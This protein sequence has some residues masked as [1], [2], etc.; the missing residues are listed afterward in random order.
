MKILKKS[1]LIIIS[2]MLL[3]C[4]P[5]YAAV[6]AEEQTVVENEQLTADNMNFDVVFAIDGSGSMKTSDAL[7]LRLTA[8]RL[9]TELAASDTSRA[10]YVQFTNV[11]MESA[12]LTEL[13]SAE[14]KEMFRNSLAGLKDSVRGTWD[15]DISLGLTEAL[16]ILKEGE[17]FGNDRNPVIILLSD[18][19]TDLPSGPRTV[20]ESN[21][22]LTATLA[23]AAQLGVPIYS[24]GLNWDGKLDTDYMQNIANQTG[25]E[26]YNITTASEFNQYIT[27]IFGNVA[28]GESTDLK[29]EYVNGRYETNFV[30]DNSSVLTANIVILTDK[31]VSDPQLTNPAGTTVPLDEEHGVIVSRDVSDA[32]RISTYTILKIMYP[33]QGVWKVSVAGEADDAVKISLLTTYDIAFV[34]SGEENATAGKD[35]TLTGRL[36]RGEEE[37]RDSDL[38]EGAT[39]TYMIVDHE[40]GIVD[41]NVPMTLDTE[42]MIFTCT[43]NLANSGNYYITANLEGRDGI[44]SKQ[45][46]QYQ[47][48]VDRAPIEVTG[49]SD[50][51][52]TLWCNPIKTKGSFNLGDYISCE[53]LSAVDCAAAD[54]EGS[55][56]T[57]NYD[58][59]TGTVTLTPMT[60]GSQTLALKITDEYGQSADL[61]VDLKVNMSWLWFIIGAVILAVI[62]VIIILIL[63]K[64][65]PV[66]K[67]PVTVELALP[68]MLLSLTPAPATLT[69]PAKKSEVILGKLIQSDPAAQSTW[70]DPVMQAN[71]TVF[72][73]KI[74]LVAGKNNEVS[75]KIMPKVPGIVLVNNQNVDTA[76]GAVYPL[77]KGDKL[78]LQFS[79][80]GANISTVYIKTGQGGDWG[81]DQNGIG[82]IFGGQGG[83]G[84]PFGGQDSFGS[85]F[86]GQG[87]F[88]SPFGG[89]GGFGDS[90]GDQGG[91]GGS[92]GSQSGFGSFG[93]NQSDFGNSFSSGSDQGDDSFGG[94]SGQDEDSFGGSQ[95]GFGGGS[96]DTGFGDGSQPD[97]GQSNN[98]FNFGGNSS[99]SKKTA[100][101][102]FGGFF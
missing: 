21:A 41:E 37:I 54:P 94:G 65:K 82:G 85:P 14:N 8:G 60:T 31:G 61:N 87:G 76:K 10:G 1:F 78:G 18:G 66:L 57:V 92:S 23:E 43:T 56:A 22:E 62:T 90:F 9:F 98:D 97:Q 42:N 68:P 89:Q 83:F 20:E 49:S 102:G 44:F 28:D 50:V 64:T 29:P 17:S 39:A 86:G 59:D 7:K 19:N 36:V 99:D 47:L 53:S 80:D 96:D 35:V 3:L 34:I 75:V 13:S 88:G 32:N 25:G 6:A 12:G 27:Q 15:T 46:A 24:I 71:L 70:A 69:M 5:G 48:S 58:K 38:L 67:E 2:F 100:D 33:E 55:I 30:I 95:G 16:R 77:R 84:N 45:S 72:L 79:P 93:G 81:F 101:D 11:I 63:K 51:P 91:F 73:D 52:M 40:G 26:F 74:K 4:M